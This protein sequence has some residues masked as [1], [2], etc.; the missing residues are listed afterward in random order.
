MDHKIEFEPWDADAL[1][2]KL[3]SFPVIVEDFFGLEWAKRFCYESSDSL[4]KSRQ[5]LERFQDYKDWLTKTTSHFEVPMIDADFSVSEDWIVRHLASRKNSIGSIDA[6]VAAEVY[7]RILLKGSSGSGKS[8]LMKRLANSFASIGKVVLY[9][10]LPDILRIHKAGN[11]FEKAITLTAI[12]GS[13]INFDGIVSYISSPDY[14]IADGLDECQRHSVEIAKKL[15]NWAEGHS[16]AKVIVACRDGIATKSFHKWQ[17]LDI[18]PLKQDDVVSF[19]R[20]VINKLL[21]SKEEREGAIEVIEG[22]VDDSKIFGLLKDSPLF[23]GL[24]AHLASTDKEFINLSKTE[25]YTASIDLAYEHLA[26]REQTVEVSKIRA[27]KVL[28]LTGHKLQ[29]NPEITE[30]VLTEYIVEELERN[31]YAFHE[32]DVIASQGIQFWKEQRVYAA[33]KGL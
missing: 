2:R 3:K 11:T 4:P 29:Q 31:G 13:G 33:S 17:H 27:M 1:S 26:Q 23:V 6:E 18:S 7:P 9:V 32:A 25:I 21:P 12:D 28:G 24:I 22:I 10:N 20:L 8:T 30:D 5:L 15:S 14:L 16:E 19:S